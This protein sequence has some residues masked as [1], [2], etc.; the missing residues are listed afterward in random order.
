[1]LYPQFTLPVDNLALHLLSFLERKG[2]QRR[3]G[4][5]GFSLVSNSEEHHGENP[6]L[7]PPYQMWK[8]LSSLNKVH[9]HEAELFLYIKAKGG[10]LIFRR[11]RR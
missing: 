11:G 4:N 9:L 7:S 3:G 6:P 10:V 8:G 2:I 1:M 5:C